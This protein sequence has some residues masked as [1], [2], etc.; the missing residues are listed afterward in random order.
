MLVT[1]IVD[2]SFNHPAVTENKFSLDIDAG[3]TI[4]NLRV[5]I[6]NFL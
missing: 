5:E 6:L 3:E 4:E 2:K 1:V